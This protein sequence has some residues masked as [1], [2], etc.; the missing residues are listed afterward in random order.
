MARRLNIHVHAVERLEDGSYGRS[1]S[2]GPGDIV[3]DWAQAVI[4]NPDVWE[5]DDE[6]SSPEPAEVKQPPRKGPGSGGPAW[7]E[8]AASKGVT[9]SF[10]SKEELIGFLEEHGHIDKG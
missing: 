2:F 10:D 4:T 6:P 3:P 1:Q 8:F 9:Q 5:G 7:V